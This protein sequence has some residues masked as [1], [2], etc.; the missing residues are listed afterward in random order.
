MDADDVVVKIALA[1]EIHAQTLR[2]V[3]D[4]HADI[5]E[6]AGAVKSAKAIAFGGEIE[7]LALLQGKRERIAREETAGIVEHANFGDGLALDL[8]FE[9]LCERLCDRVFDWAGDLALGVGILRA[10]GRNYREAGEQRSE[11]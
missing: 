10:D 6:I 11:D 2:E 5:G 3:G 7:G 9:R 8:V 1:D 4:Q